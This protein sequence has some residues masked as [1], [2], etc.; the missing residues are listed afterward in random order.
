MPL[1]RTDG[2]KEVPLRL[3]DMVKISLCGCAVRA[4]HKLLDLLEKEC[5]PTLSFNIV[6]TQ[7]LEFEI[8]FSANM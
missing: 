6:V 8:F 5:S 1:Q 2:W 4:R 3:L 7:N